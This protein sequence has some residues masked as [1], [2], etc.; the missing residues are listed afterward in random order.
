MS[1]SKCRRPY[2]MPCNTSNI[3]SSRSCSYYLFLPLVFSLQDNFQCTLE[4]ESKNH[5]LLI[6]RLIKCAEDNQKPKG[7]L[8]QKMIKSMFLNLK[9]NNEQENS[10]CKMNM[11]SRDKPTTSS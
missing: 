4:K 11:R 9:N 8:T 2:V 6:S 5:R 3:P 10:P 1:I 7:K